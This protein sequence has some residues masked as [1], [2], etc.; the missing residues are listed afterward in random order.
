MKGKIRYCSKCLS[1]EMYIK[2][3]AQQFLK[4]GT[5]SSI[6][7]LICSLNQLAIIY[8]TD[9]FRIS[10]VNSILRKVPVLQRLPSS[11]F[12]SWQNSRIDT[13]INQSRD[14][15]QDL[16]R[17]KKKLDSLPH[18][19]FVTQNRYPGALLM[20][21][22]CLAI[23]ARGVRDNYR[24]SAF[25]GLAVGLALPIWATSAIGS[26]VAPEVEREAWLAYGLLATS[27][28]TFLALFV[29]KGRQL[30][31]LGREGANHA[32]TCTLRHASAAHAA[33]AAAAHAAADRDDRLSSLPG[34]GY[35][36]SF[37]HFK[38]PPEP[39]LKAKMHYH[40]AGELSIFDLN[41]ANGPNG[42]HND[43]FM[44][45]SDAVVWY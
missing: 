2:L 4:V 38:P 35:S 21:T 1:K 12:H 26:L 15:E 11:L 41:I 7:A 3:Q 27:V 17:S 19:I 40:S 5:S 9:Y 6:R 34:S 39:S 42:I 32:V 23:R 24:E 13:S 29:P 37:F 36:P 28:L 16:I 45:R 43:L 18:D 14:E 31:A 25:I 10:F 22:T 8:H 20:A 30:A 33:A 44:P